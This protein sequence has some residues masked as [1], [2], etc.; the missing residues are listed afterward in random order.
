MESFRRHATVLFSAILVII[1]TLVVIQLWLLSAALEGLLA[2]DTGLLVPAAVASA[3]LFAI[4][5]GLLLYALRVD[6]RI[7]GK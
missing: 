3:V 2:H 5:G 7:R 4:N 1:G 6:G